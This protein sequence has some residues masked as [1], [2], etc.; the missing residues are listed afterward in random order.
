MTC[1]YAAISLSRDK[2]QTAFNKDWKGPDNILQDDVDLSLEE[3]F[4]DIIG[5]QGRD[6]IEVERNPIPRLPERAIAARLDALSIEHRMTHLPKN[7]LCDICN[8]ARLYSKRIRSR[9][10]ADP[11]ED[12]EEPEKFGEQVAC[13]H[14]IVL[15]SSTKDKEYAVF[16]V[17]DS[18]SGVLQAYPTVTKS[19]EHAAESLRHFTGRLDGGFHCFTPKPLADMAPFSRKRLDFAKRQMPHVLFG[20]NLVVWGS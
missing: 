1:E 8:R 6:R 2:W 19:A 11:E 14:V 12:I 5:D 13:D 9:P 4:A 20:H 7:P 15:K 3:Q 18:Y 10:I 17:R 16:I